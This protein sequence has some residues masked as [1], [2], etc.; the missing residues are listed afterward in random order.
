MAYFPGALLDIWGW[1]VGATYELNLELSGQDDD[2]HGGSKDQKPDTETLPTKLVK[3]QNFKLNWPRVQTEKLQTKFFCRVFR[4]KHAQVVS[5][6]SWGKQSHCHLFR[7]VSWKLLLPISFPRHFPTPS[8]THHGRN[9]FLAIQFPFSGCQFWHWF[10]QSL[11]KFFQKLFD[12]SAFAQWL[13]IGPIQ[14][15]WPLPSVHR[16]WKTFNRGRLELA[17]AVRAYAHQTSE[18]ILAHRLAK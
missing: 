6:C 17:I 13:L 11:K 5:E 4:P 3:L 10:T 1:P 2:V 9:L 14:L 7:T 16:W 8:K 15:P 12:E 18:C